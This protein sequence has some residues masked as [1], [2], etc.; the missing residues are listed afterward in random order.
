MATKTRIQKL[1]DKAWKLQSEYI[2]KRDSDSFTELAECCTCNIVKPRKEMHA[3]HYRHRY[4]DF[5]E[6]NVHAQC[7][8]CNT[9]RSG[10]LDKYTLFLIDKYGFE[11]IKELDDAFHAHKRKHDSTGKKYSVEELELIIVGLKEKINE[12]E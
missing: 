2:R 7:S 9:Y 5:H 8:G 10:E 12:L 1:F 6:K 11:V 4:L 3:G